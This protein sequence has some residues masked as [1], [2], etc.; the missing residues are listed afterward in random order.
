MFSSDRLRT[1]ILAKNT[2]PQKS[3]DDEKG[4]GEK[5]REQEGKITEYNRTEVQPADQERKLEWNESELNI[6]FPRMASVHL[7]ST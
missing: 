1:G 4:K 7:L 2:V 6:S 5:E 3:G